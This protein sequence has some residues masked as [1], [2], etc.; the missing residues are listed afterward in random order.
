MASQFH[1]L[2]TAYN[3]LR[4]HQIMVDTSGHNISNA[5]NEGY[6]RQRVNVVAADS[7]YTA[8]GELGQGSRIESIV[9]VHDEFTYK[10]Y[11]K[12][13]S[14]K[15]FASYQETKLKEVSSYMPDI[16]ESGLYNDLQNYF[17]AW[18]TFSANPEENSQK[19]NL[20]QK[21]ITFTEN[22]QM[23]RDK[24]AT[25]QRN[26]N[27]E[28]I[29]DIKEINRM[30][31]RIGEI[32][33]KILDKEA[34]NI[35]FGNDL[36]DE[37]DRLETAIMKMV[38]VSV[39]KQNLDKNS[40]FASEQ[41]DF[42]NYYH[43]N[44]GGYS[45]IDGKGVHPIV[46]D[47]KTNANG[48]IQVY[49]RNENW[50]DYDITDKLKGGEI[51][52][53]LELR[54]SIPR[55]DDNGFENGKLQ[56]YIDHLDSLAETIIEKT[57]SIYGESATKLMESNALPKTKGDLEIYKMDDVHINNGSFN[58]RCFKIF[59][60]PTH[61]WCIKFKCIFWVRFTY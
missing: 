28:L 37:R 13:L 41:A 43:M 56:K 44:I 54:G 17:N 31:K 26:I 39:F 27:D 57:N 50:V 12:A 5:E 42:E 46:A 16:E 22:L 47:N 53:I 48:M 61:H 35:N 45:L 36:R 19:I 25:M 23:V 52:A 30:A 60:K 51:G 29:M 15:E 4:T 18:E 40:E 38:D 55:Q 59:L 21:T 14:E 9:R 3:G 34:N 32:N 6:T 20:A 2:N 7:L 33:D 24:L 10:R 1:T 49:H 11:N 8:R 58:C